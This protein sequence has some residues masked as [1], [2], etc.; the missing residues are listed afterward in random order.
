M[1]V[2]ASWVS[3]TYFHQS[4]WETKQGKKYSFL[5]QREMPSSIKQK[6][7]Q[8]PTTN[9]EDHGPNVWKC[10][11]SSK[12]IH[13]WQPQLKCFSS[14]MRSRAVVGPQKSKP[15]SISN[16]TRGEETEG[17]IVLM[18][19]LIMPKAGSLQKSWL[20]GHSRE[21]RQ[22]NKGPMALCRAYTGNIWKSKGMH[23][24]DKIVIRFLKIFWDLKSH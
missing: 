4:S 11:K 16:Y 15:I 8:L 24:S 5:K 20:W 19:I 14:A 17:K 23:S 12:M 7:P 21:A 10:A 9:Q 18:S 3:A 6:F 1:K 22:S 2:W 13:M